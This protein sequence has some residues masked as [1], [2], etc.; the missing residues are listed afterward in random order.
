MLAKGQKE[1]VWG[2]RELFC[3]LI[4]VMVTR[5]YIHVKAYRTD[6]TYKKDNFTVC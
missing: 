6:S 5:I 2:R 4:F 1:G 3:I